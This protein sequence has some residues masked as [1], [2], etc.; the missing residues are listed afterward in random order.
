MMPDPQPTQLHRRPTVSSPLVCPACGEEADSET[1]YFSD[2]GV[3]HAG[4][5]CTNRHLWLTSWVDA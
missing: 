3:P 2:D 4:G 1:S 5:T